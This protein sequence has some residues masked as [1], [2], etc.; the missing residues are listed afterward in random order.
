MAKNKREGYGKILDFW[1]PP[2]EAGEAIGCIATTFTFDAIFFEEECLG[3]FLKMETDAEEDAVTYIIQRYEKL[4]TIQC[5]SV[6]VDQIHSKQKRNP[7]WDM[8]SMRYQGTFHPKISLLYWSGNIRLVVAS[9]NLSKSGYR[10]N[11]EIFGVLDF[12]LENGKINTENTHVPVLLAFT[13]YLKN[14]IHRNYSLSGDSA[15]NK[16]TR[17]L[18]TIEQIAEQ[19]LVESSGKNPSNRGI[20]YILISPQSENLFTQLSQ[21]WKKYSQTPPSHAMVTSPFYDRPEHRNMPAEEIWSI[22]KLR[23]E[24]EVCY[25]CPFENLSAPRKKWLLK[26]PRQLETS[27]PRGRS[28]IKVNFCGISKLSSDENG[29]ECIRPFHLKSIWLENTEWLLYMIGSSNFTSAGTGLTKKSNYEANLVYV[30]NKRKD[31]ATYKRLSDSHFKGQEFRKEEIEFS[32]EY[33]TEE[34]SDPS[35][36]ILPWFFRSCEAVWDTGTV[37]KL[38]FNTNVKINGFRIFYDSK[39]TL[40]DY[41]TWQNAGMPESVHIPNKEKFIPSGFNVDLQNQ[42]PYAW[43]PLTIADS[44]VLP[45]PDALLNLDFK[46]LIEILSSH[47]PLHISLTRILGRRKPGKVLNDQTPELLDPHKRVDTSGFILQRTRR[48]SAALNS[49]SAK[50]CKPI[51]TMESLQWRLYGPVGVKAFCDALYREIEKNNQSKELKEEEMLFFLAELVNELKDLKLRTFNNSLGEDV[52]RSEI[53]IFI[54]ALELE[55]KALIHKLKHTPILKYAKRS[56]YAA[57]KL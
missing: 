30:V 51:Y 27:Q 52:V 49:L 47:T 21:I 1:L 12:P 40:Y 43:W 14:I 38:T 34:E 31:N 50:L 6:L 28:S 17:L 54:K 9:A 39:E 55:H 36:T 41:D 26:A 45:T 3:R 15:N 33:S 5:A 57:L 29:K 42:Q 22:L 44:R 23:G 7:Q 2:K 13:D 56:F 24:A 8:I 46:D 11:L 18:E 16:S 19:Q 35:V 53:L 32:T 10:E 37:I 48:V 25:I 20:E 4:N